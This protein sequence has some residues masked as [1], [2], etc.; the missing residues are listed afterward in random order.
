MIIIADATTTIMITDNKS[1]TQ[2]VRPKYLVGERVRL[3]VGHDK[4]LLGRIVVVEIYGNRVT[5]QWDGRSKPELRYPDQ[6]E[7]A[8]DTDING[9]THTHQPTTINFI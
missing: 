6:I 5:V 9:K 3:I 1:R 2:R 8:V 7:H 4:G